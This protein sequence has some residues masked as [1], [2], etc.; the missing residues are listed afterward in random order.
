[1]PLCSTAWGTVSS[2]CGCRSTGI[3]WQRE[4]RWWNGS[5]APC[6]SITSKGC[7]RISTSA[8]FRPIAHAS[9]PA[10]Q[11][12]APISTPSSASSFGQGDKWLL[13]TLCA[14][15]IPDV[16][17]GVGGSNALEVSRFGERAAGRGKRLAGRL[18]VGAD[19]SHEDPRHGGIELRAGRLDHALQGHLGAH[20]F[21]VGAVADHG[22]EGV[23]VRHDLRA[24]RDGVAD[25]AIGVALAVVA[26]MMVQHHGQ[27]SAE[28]GVLL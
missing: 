24:E 11:T 22:V 14:V 21:A 2:T 12:S 8:S 7:P 19:H 9:C 3:I 10:S 28:V 16:V 20:A 4:T 23:G 17:L 18:K 27:H 15:E 26:L 13:A 1:M 5:K 25:E 6:S